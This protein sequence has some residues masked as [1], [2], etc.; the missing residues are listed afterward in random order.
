M[1]SWRKKLIT[2]S[3]SPYSG[4]AEVSTKKNGKLKPRLVLDYKQLNDRTIKSCWPILTI[5]KNFDKP[6]GSAFFTSKDMPWEFYQLPK[7]LDF[8]KYT[9]LSTLF[10]SF[11]SLRSPYIFQSLVEHVFVRL[12]WSITIPYIDDG[13]KFSKKAHQKTAVSFSQKTRGEYKYQS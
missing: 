2:L 3:Q 9:S 8:Q 5:E 12:T 10:V 13:I 11:K 6:L 7:E 4:P 1:P